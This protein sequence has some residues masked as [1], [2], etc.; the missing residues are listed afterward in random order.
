MSRF[1]PT[2]NADVNDLRR[3]AILG[4]GNRTLPYPTAVV[5]FDNVHPNWLIRTQAATILDA[6]RNLDTP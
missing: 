6:V 3:G 4:T 2:S 5:R 1:T